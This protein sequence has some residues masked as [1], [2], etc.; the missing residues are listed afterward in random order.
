VTQQAPSAEET[1]W[2]GSPSHWKSFGTYVLCV[3]LSG[4]F[5]WAAVYFR[6]K[7]NAGFLGSWNRHVGLAFWVLQ[8]VPAILALR[9]FILTK[10]TTYKL[11]T[12]RILTASGV[13][14]R[15]TDNL[16]LYRVDDFKILQPFFLRLVGRGTLVVVASDRSSPEL[17]LEA[18]PDSQGLRDTMRKHVE[19]CRDR[20]RTRV[21]DME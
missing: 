5:A 4:L 7:G 14:F 9:S 6:S 3:V 20:K 10:T 18:I 8:A 16:E 12:E 17:P 1:V 2:E 13:F 21:V 11:T 19:A 15:K